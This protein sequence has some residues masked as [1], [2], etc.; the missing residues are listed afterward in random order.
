MRILILVFVMGLL[1]SGCTHKFTQEKIDAN[2]FKGKTTK[3][4]VLAIFGEP[5]GKYK[6][7]GMK[8]VSGEKAQV[9]HNSF[10]VWLYSP[11]QSKLMDFFEPELLRI[12][13]DSDNIVSNFYFDD[14]GD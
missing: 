4:E 10:E 11:H 13:F 3:Q 8:M 1:T 2:L 14:D 5:D 6:S 9:L 12:I 7:P